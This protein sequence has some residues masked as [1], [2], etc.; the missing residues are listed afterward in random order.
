M[1]CGRYPSF[2]P[3][4]IY[5]L[6]EVLR[7]QSEIV[8]R[9]MCRRFLVKHLTL[10]LQHHFLTLK[11]TSVYEDL[12]EDS[13]FRRNTKQTSVRAVAWVCA[14]MKVETNVTWSLPDQY[15]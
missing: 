15:S 9:R 2:Q 13:G 10:K 14:P 7:G 8:S 6:Y 11:N 3:Q 12:V 4:E 1:N 5:E